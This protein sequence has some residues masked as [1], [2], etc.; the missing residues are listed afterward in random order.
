MICPH[1]NL[2]R[3]TT[4]DDVI[5]RGCGL[6]LHDDQIPPEWDQDEGGSPKT[7]GGDVPASVVRGIAASCS[8][9]RLCGIIEREACR[10]AHLVGVKKRHEPTVAACVYLACQNT[11][12]ARTQHEFEAALNVPGKALG[13][14]ISRIRRSLP[15]PHG[16]GD[17]RRMFPRIVSAFAMEWTGGP[18][19]PR[20]LEDRMRAAY[21]AHWGSMYAARTI[22]LNT[23]L[24]RSLQQGLRAL[25]V[26][27]TRDTK[28]LVKRV[29]GVRTL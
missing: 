11:S 26:Q 24:A 14:A 16:K 4:A 3:D 25:G 5:C 6:V 29:C 10:L 21:D 2:V 15:E 9:M 19:S 7:A 13:R 12:L 18:L 17:L 8:I 28:S 20:K 1:T 27:D 23:A 22:S